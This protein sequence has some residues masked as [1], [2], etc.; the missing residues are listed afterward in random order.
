MALAAVLQHQRPHAIMQSM[1]SSCKSDACLL[2]PL[3]APAPHHSLHKREGLRHGKGDNSLLDDIAAFS[4]QIIPST[5]VL[6][7]V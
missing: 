4:V 1:C 3:A 2:L 6:E 7:Q 5:R